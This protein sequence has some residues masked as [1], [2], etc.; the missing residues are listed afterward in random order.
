VVQY[1]LSPPDEIQTRIPCVQVCKCGKPAGVLPHG[2]CRRYYMKEAQMVKQ[3]AFRV[4]VGLHCNVHNSSPNRCSRFARFAM[5]HHHQI[6]SISTSS[7]ALKPSF[8]WPATYL[9][10]SQKKKTADVSK[11][12]ARCQEILKILT[13]LI[14]MIILK[15]FKTLNTNFKSH[16]RTASSSCCGAQLVTWLLLPPAYGE[17]R[18][19]W[20]RVKGKCMYF[21]TKSSPNSEIALR[22]G[23]FPGFAH[24]F[25]W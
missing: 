7:S 6:S 19:I 20:V 17:P 24:V 21:S 9:T 18:L 14:L 25:F 1:V 15:R 3:F 11:S 23:R 22:F 13:I 10:I 2:S 16:V 12:S 4:L 5:Y 8:L